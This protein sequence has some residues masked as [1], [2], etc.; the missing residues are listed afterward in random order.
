MELGRTDDLPQS[1]I[2]TA[3]FA[4]ADATEETDGTSAATI[5]NGAMYLSRNL[6]VDGLT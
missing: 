1:T 3:P 4:D 5:T 6:E 2:V